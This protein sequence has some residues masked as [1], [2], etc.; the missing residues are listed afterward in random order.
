MGIQATR[1]NAWLMIGALKGESVYPRPFDEMEEALV[2]AATHRFTIGGGT[3]PGHT[4]DAVSALIAEMWGADMFLNLTAVD[5]AYTADP[6]EDPKAVWIPRMTTG[7]LC[8]LVS[9]TERGAGSHSVLDPLAATV[10]HR[11]GIKTFILDGRDIG[12]LVDCLKGND[13]H[14]TIV[15]PGK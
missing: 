4:T 3:H 6:K 9:S 15:L 13:F 1:L 2:G 12:N 11:S 14:G 10:V 8:D 7:E 5:G